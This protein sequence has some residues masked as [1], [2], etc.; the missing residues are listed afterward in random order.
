MQIEITPDYLIAQGL[1]STFPARF[2]AKVNK[3]GPTPLHRA[4]LGPCWLWKPAIATCRHGI[5][6]KGRHCDG[7][8]GA[9]V[10]AWILNIGLVPDGFCVCHHCDNPPCVRPSHLF[11]GTSAQ[12]S[13]DMAEKGR[14]ARGIKHGMSKLSE[15]EVLEI[16]NLRRL[17]VAGTRV[18]SMFNISPQMVCQIWKGHNWTHI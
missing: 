3:D 11:L 16:R 1:S 14:A 10:A 8:M 17:G 18:A 2:W 5:I 15:K 12:N 6:M 7:C 13:A 4:E 9:H